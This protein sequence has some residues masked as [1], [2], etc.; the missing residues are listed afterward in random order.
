[1]RFLLLWISS[2][3]LV[4]SQ[5]CEYHTNCQSCTN[6]LC[7]WCTY[8]SSCLELSFSCSGPLY[9]PDSCPVDHTGGIVVSIIGSIACFVCLCLLMIWCCKRRNT[10]YTTV[11]THTDPSL[12]TGNPNQT[13]VPAGYCQPGTSLPQYVIQTGYPVAPQ[14]YIVPGSNLPPYVLQTGYPVA[15]QYISTVPP[16]CAPAA[17]LAPQYLTNKV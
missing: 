8:E 15:P 5:T 12:Q 9:S 10:H 16:A 1:M 2:L 7:K 14:P 13:A 6:T 3:S 11:V 4:L 17:P